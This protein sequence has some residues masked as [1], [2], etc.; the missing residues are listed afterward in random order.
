MQQE[1]SIRRATMNDLN[2]MLE[3]YELARKQ[4]R[5]N[6]NPNQWKNYPSKELLE[7]DIKSGISYVIESDSKVIGTFV[8]I[9]GKDPTYR[10]IEKGSWLNS[11]PYGTIHRIASD[12]THKGL[13]KLVEEYCSQQIDNIRIDTHEDNKIMRY[14]LEKS[15]FL[16]CGII[17]TYDGSP[18]IAYQ[19]VY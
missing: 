2:R 1:R 12:G 13:F 17:Y 8:F 11:E 4:M 19:K 9:I 14:I 5:L 6:G 10:V 16:K 3:I 7:E 15:G 18:R